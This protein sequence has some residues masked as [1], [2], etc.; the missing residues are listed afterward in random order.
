MIHLVSL[1]LIISSL[2]HPSYASKTP[3]LR[4]RKLSES[5]K[6]GSSIENTNE[7]GAMTGGRLRTTLCA[8]KCKSDCK[9]Y[10]TPLNE[11]YNGLIMFPDDESWG[12]FDIMDVTMTD[13][14]MPGQQ[15]QRNFY[16]TTDGSCGEAAGGQIPGVPTDDFTLPFGE[17]VGP[18]GAPRPWGTMNTL[19]LVE[20]E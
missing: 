17:C 8:D 11:C 14:T 5:D 12:Q 15:F 7:G 2:N 10:V 18:F 9:T 19:D 20:E 16:E 13:Y 1:L 4:N 3:P 6:K